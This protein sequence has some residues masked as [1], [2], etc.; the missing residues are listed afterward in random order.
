M[1]PRGY[2]NNYKWRNTSRS[3]FSNKS[4]AKDY[5]NSNFW[6]SGN[7]YLKKDAHCKKNRTQTTTQNAAGK[8][9]ETNSTTSDDPKVLEEIAKEET[10]LC[11]YKYAQK[12]KKK[13][14]E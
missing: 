10:Y 11:K 2:T 4:S 7:V 14:G 3:N 5:N 13:S 6:I 12:T 8:A 1:T 9:L